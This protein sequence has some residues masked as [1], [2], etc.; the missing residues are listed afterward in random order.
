MEEGEGRCRRHRVSPDVAQVVADSGR[1][2]LW[3]DDGSLA[4]SRVRE[5]AARVIEGAIEPAHAVA[6][7][8]N[9][10]EVSLILDCN[11]HTKNGRPEIMALRPAPVAVVFHGFAGTMG[12]R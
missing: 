1:V 3:G 10:A 9:A 12:A 4:G 2:P 6:R 7:A 8:I 5:L 11:G